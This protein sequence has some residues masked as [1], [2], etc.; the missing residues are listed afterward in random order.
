MFCPKC[1]YL[2]DITKNIIDVEGKQVEKNSLNINQFLNIVLDDN[3]VDVNYKLDFNLNELTSNPKFKKLDEETR[4]II[5]SQ[6]ENLNQGKN[7]QVYFTCNNCG[8]YKTVVPGTQLYNKSYV[9]K[10]TNSLENPILKS[11][12]PTLVRTRDYI[13]KNKDCPTH[14][15]KIIAEATFFRTKTSF[16]LTYV[17]C[18]C[19]TSWLMN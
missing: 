18:V 17:C 13:C 11:L 19:K 1:N 6:Y 9:I 2:L 16:Q 3:E 12:D 14:K 4:N 15:D 5:I 8:F 10:N 7:V